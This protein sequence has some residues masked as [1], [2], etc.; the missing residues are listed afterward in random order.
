VVGNQ[1]DFSVNYPPTPFLFFEQQTE[2]PCVIGA[3]RLKSVPEVPSVKELGLT[4]S[5]TDGWVFSPLKDAETH[6]G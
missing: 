1:V 5:T 3:K 6:R 4:P 2:S